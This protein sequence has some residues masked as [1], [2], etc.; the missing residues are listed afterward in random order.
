MSIETMGGEVVAERIDYYSVV[1]VGRTADN[2]SGIARRRFTAEGRVD[3]SLRRDFTWGPT[4]AVIDWE[5][6]NLSGELVRITEAEAEA[7]VERFREKW[8]HPA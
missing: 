5:Y 4:T 8:G 6:G 3:E 2:P 7:Q 1:G